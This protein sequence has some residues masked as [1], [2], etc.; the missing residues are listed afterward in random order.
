M[1]L[2]I[3]TLILTGSLLAA[4]FSTRYDV[5]VGMFGKVGYADVT[6]KKDENSYEMMLV[7]ITT[8][9]AATLTGK[10][11]DTFISKGRI[12][13]GRYLP[14]SFVKIKKTT[15]EEK[16]PVSYTHNRAHET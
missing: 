5:D 1:R 11:V 8:G 7:A 16:I 14:Q 3:F 10:R 4:D 2:L 15:R 6:L 12:V 9:T 13:E